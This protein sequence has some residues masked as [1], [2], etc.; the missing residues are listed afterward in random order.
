VHAAPVA[1]IAV[2]AGAPDLPRNTSHVR[3]HLGP[4]FAVRAH[5]ARLYAQDDPGLSICRGPMCPE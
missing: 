4:K 1:G 3:L 5:A 2:I